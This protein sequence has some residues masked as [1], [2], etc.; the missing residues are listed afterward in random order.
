MLFKRVFKREVLKHFSRKAFIGICFDMSIHPDVL[1]TLAILLSLPEVMLSLNEYGKNVIARNFVDLSVN[2]AILPAKEDF[3]GRLSVKIGNFLN[4]KII[5]NT[6]LGNSWLLWDPSGPYNQTIFRN[7]LNYIVDVLLD[8]KPNNTTE[9]LAPQLLYKSF[10]IES[11]YKEIENGH[12]KISLISDVILILD[13]DFTEFNS[14][15][16]EILIH[17]LLKTAKSEQ[18]SSERK[19]FAIHEIIFPEY[20]VVARNNSM[21]VKFS[22]EIEIRD[23]K[24]ILHATMGHYYDNFASPIIYFMMDD[25]SIIEVGPYFWRRRD[26]MPKNLKNFLGVYTKK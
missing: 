3:A 14:F 16:A 19:K 17:N 25:N 6:E 15:S 1:P 11:T 9:A 12:K 10:C 13:G 18:T 4:I 20:L 8:D 21:E 2:S 22:K 7:L 24:Y 26:Y 5:K 23:T